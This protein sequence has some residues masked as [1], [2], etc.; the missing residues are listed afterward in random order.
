MPSVRLVVAFVSALWSLSALAAAPSTPTGF[1]IDV[2][3]SSAAE[4]FWN[5]STVEDGYVR[6]YEIRHNG[7][8]VA[9]VDALSFY[10]DALHPDGAST[11]SITAVNFDGERSGTQ[12]IS[13]D[14]ERHSDSIDDRPAPPQNVTAQVYSPTA[15]EIFWD[16]SIDPVSRYEITIDGAVTATTEGTSYFTDSLQAGRT[17]AIDV[18]GIDT[19]GSRSLAETI[20]LNTNGN[21]DTTT[22]RR[23][24]E[25]AW[26]W[27]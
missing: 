14:G 12:S 2:Y 1:R 19:K 22:I 20:A 6:G 23:F 13:T 16:R 10:T 25:M 24:A 5:R 11:F 4:L 27:G 3:S 26:R 7:D 15:I 21:T 17:Y 8:V 9:V 18:V